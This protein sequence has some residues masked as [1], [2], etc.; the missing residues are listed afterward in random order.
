[1]RSLEE[2]SAQVPNWSRE[3]PQRFWDPGRKLLLSIRRYQSSRWTLVR[4]WCV[5]RHRFWSVVSGAEIPLTSQIGGGLLI[6][7]PNG[8]VIN[9][10]AR[11]GVNCLIFQQ[12][13]IGSGARGDIGLPVIGGHVDIGA[14]AKVLGSVSDPIILASARTRLSLLAPQLQRHPHRSWIIVKL[15]DGRPQRGVVGVDV[16]RQLTP[17]PGAREDEVAGILAADH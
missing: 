6:S 8:I 1:M 2:I 4:K 10:G 5:F 17:W 7:H 15:D 16:G 11:I 9:A 3:R 14:G 12:V 13:T